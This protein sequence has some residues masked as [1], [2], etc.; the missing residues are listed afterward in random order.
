[1]WITWKHR[2]TDFASPPSLEDK[3]TIFQERVYGWQLNIAD[4][5]ANGQTQGAT[6]PAVPHSDF[7]GLQIQL[8]YFEAIAK[9]EAGY[10]GD[11]ESFSHFKKGVRLV[12]PALDSEDKRRVDSLLELLWKKGRCG[13][14]HGSMPGVGIL[15]GDLSDV[16]MA[17][18]SKPPQLVI[19][20]HRLPKEL[21]RHLAAYVETLR[22]IRNAELRA[23]FEARFDY[24]HRA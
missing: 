12:F 21:K 9:Y 20:P 19:D 10:V 14:Y 15:I 4:I 18:I 2:E 7:A 13:L 11:R 5:L 22:D 16:A 3:I 1:M 24:N 23:N 17:F 8:A 6:L